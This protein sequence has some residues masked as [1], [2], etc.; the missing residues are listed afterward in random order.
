MVLF[1][2]KILLNCELLESNSLKP[3]HD[4]IICNCLVAVAALVTARLLAKDSSLKESRKLRS[5]E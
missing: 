5:G 2:L 1:D 4:T 3:A